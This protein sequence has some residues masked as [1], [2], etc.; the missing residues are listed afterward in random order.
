MFKIDCPTIHCSRGDAGAFT[1]KIPIVDRNNYIKYKDVSNNVYWY[2]KNNDTLYNSNYE[3]ADSQIDT[4][5][6]ECYQFQEGDKITFNIYNK[7]GYDKTPLMSK[8]I[9]VAEICESVYFHLTEKDTTFGKPV[10]KPTIFWYDIT[11]NDKLTVICYDE[12]GA[13]EFIEYPAKGDE[14]E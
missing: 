6:M 4:L 7:N 3:K 10:N 13:K 12:E 5:T 14:E 11:L 8:E 1:I 9:F 2:D